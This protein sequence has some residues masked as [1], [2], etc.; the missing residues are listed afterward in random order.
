[1]PHT[2]SQAKTKKIENMNLPYRLEQAITKL[3]TAFHSGS[4]DP[5][6]CHHC[7]VGNICDNFDTWKHLTESHGST[8]LS[9]LGRLNEAVG[10]RINGY[11]P[12]ELLTIETV[13]LQACGYTL[14]FRRGEKK[15]DPRDKE[16]QYRGLCAVVEYLCALD[17]VDNVMDISR[18]FQYEKERPVYELRLG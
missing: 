8:R 14:P 10:R 15:V 2:A 9:Y 7:A 18:L 17:G 12:S 3:Y 13:F 16:A 4:L 5:E 6:N 1:M 11:S